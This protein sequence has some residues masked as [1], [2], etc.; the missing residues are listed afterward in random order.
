VE[1][2]LAAI[3]TAVA[4]LPHLADHLLLSVNASPAT[5][6][7][8]RLMRALG[9]E[10]GPR[11]ILELTEQTCID[12]YNAL[13]EALEQVRRA[14]VRLA[15]DDAGAGYAGLQQILGLRPDIIKLDINITHGM[16]ADPVRRALAA[17][18]VSFARD[19]GATIVA[20]GIE[21]PAELATLESLGVH[22]GQGYHLG[23]P[24][25][26]VTTLE[27]VTGSGA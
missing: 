8:P 22:W 25:P 12:D 7:S 4:A 1:L 5:A 27:A 24:A 15:V 11:L 3:E 23:R 17:S 26:L 19:T 18:L 14:G 21:T 20:E 16:D 2:E 10:A 13:L 6:M 9:P